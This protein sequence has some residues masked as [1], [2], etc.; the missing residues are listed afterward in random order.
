MADIIVVAGL[1]FGDEGKG[2]AVDFL[3]RSHAAKMVVRHNGGAQAA[4]NV[5][6]ADGRHHTFAQFGS[7]TFNPG[8]RTHLS[9][10]MLVNPIFL[11]REE[12][13]LRTLGVEDAYERLTIERQALITNPFQVA[14]NR[15]REMIRAGARH[16]SCGM[17][18][19]ETVCDAVAHPSEAVRAEDFDSPS[20][21]RLKLATSQVRK[22]EEIVRLLN[23]REVPPVMQREWDVL[24]DHTLPA[25]VADT[26]LQ[27]A[28]RVRVVDETY[29]KTAMNE[30]GTIV[31]EG[32][33]GV[34]LDQDHGFFPH[35][36]RSTT[37]FA[38]A[39]DLIRGHGESVAKIGVLRAYTT[40]HGPGPFPTEDASMGL[41]DPHNGFGE[42]QREFRVGHLDAV[43]AHYA[44]H[45]V[46]DGV[47]GIMM[48]HLDRLQGRSVKVCTGYDGAG[49][50]DDYMGGK[51]R[52]F[53]VHNGMIHGLKP[54]PL[55]TKRTDALAAVE[56]DYE[57]FNTVE[58]AV[59]F[60]SGELRSSI[61]YLAY[62]PKAEDWRTC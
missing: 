27:L 47:D 32:A 59:R 24:A 58:E 18:I 1:G 30:R 45:Q 36:T 54:G 20:K 15:L 28:A 29:L 46:C 3:A 61:R 33:Q 10:H 21:L 50:V 44:I 38:N 56:P 13:H 62:G 4:H 25:S 39:L 51:D 5:V 11:M 35:V 16:G 52:Y 31:F 26:Y 23:P 9:R 19:N 43:L 12:L 2:S 48:T 8:C 17:G 49:R 22:Y 6:L 60:T 57:E 14:A 53:H 41:P 34:L 42:W 55:D 7:G 37:T 40:R